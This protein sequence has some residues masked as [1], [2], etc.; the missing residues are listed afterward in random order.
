MQGSRKYAA[1]PRSYQVQTNVFLEMS[2]AVASSSQ[3]VSHTPPCKDECFFRFHFP[4]G[5]IVKIVD[6]LFLRKLNACLISNGLRGV[7]ICRL[8]HLLDELYVCLQGSHPVFSD[9]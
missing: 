5:S 4:E 2:S 7:L 1:G 3:P 9:G 8:S 6:F